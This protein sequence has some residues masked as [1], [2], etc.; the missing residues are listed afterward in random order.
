MSCPTVLAGISLDCGNT[1]G[2]V[3]EVYIAPYEDILSVEVSQETGDIIA[4]TMA[5]TKQFFKYK[6]RKNTAS[7]TPNGNIDDAAGTSY[8]QSD[9]V[10]QF[11]KMDSAKRL[12]IVSLAKSECAV[13]VKDANDTYWFMGKDEYVSCTAYSGESGTGRADFNG[14]KVTLTD[15]SKE[16]PYE[17]DEAIIADLLAAGA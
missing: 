5:A 9:L 4:I 3:K 15:M 17:V 14:Y 2:G 7:F 13:I 10:M 8:T 12:E 16:L 11:T 6:F 1:S